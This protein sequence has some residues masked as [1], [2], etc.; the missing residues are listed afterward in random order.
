MEFENKKVLIVG[1][2]A[3]N[4]KVVK[5]LVNKG[6]K[7]LTVTDSKS[8]EESGRVRVIEKVRKSYPKTSFM[9]ESLGAD[10][11]RAV[12]LFKGEG[13]DKLIRLITPEKVLGVR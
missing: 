4:V 11:I 3:S 13:T 9:L 8:E 2:G 5:Y 10:L 1:L 6:L 12:V 7:S